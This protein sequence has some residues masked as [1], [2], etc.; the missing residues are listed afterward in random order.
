MG[1][2]IFIAVILNFAVWA[3]VG[4]SLGGDALNGKAASGKYFLGGKGRLTE[5][6]RAVYA[7][8][9][10]HTL[11]TIASFAGSLGLGLYLEIRGLRR[12][13]SQG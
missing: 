6:S 1:S 10:A 2:G 12:A 11:V 4:M 9:Y 7:Y 13:R 3:F 5:V 8:S